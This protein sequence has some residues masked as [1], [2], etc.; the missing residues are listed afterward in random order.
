MGILE[1]SAALLYRRTAGFTDETS[2]ES[3]SPNSRIRRDLS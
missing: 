3:A 1:A 2:D